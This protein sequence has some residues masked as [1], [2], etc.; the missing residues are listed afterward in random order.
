MDRVDKL[1]A[2]WNLMNRSSSEIAVVNDIT[3]Y[4]S[5]VSPASLTMAV[6]SKQPVNAKGIIVA[7][8]TCSCLLIE[9]E[10][11]IIVLLFPLVPRKYMLK[12]KVGEGCMVWCRKFPCKRS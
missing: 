12:A 6:S 4:L 2:K 9:F 3:D 7:T 5:V 1:E 10:L 8:L 11:F